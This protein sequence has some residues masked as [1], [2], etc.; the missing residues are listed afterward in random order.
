MKE[1][2]KLVEA[3]ATAGLQMAQIAEQEQ[4]AAREQE[5][6]AVPSDQNDANRI[7]AAAIVKK[8][9]DYVRGVA[10]DDPDGRYKR[11]YENVAPTYFDFLAKALQD[12]GR[13]TLDQA[14]QAQRIVEIWRQY[15]RGRAAKKMVSKVHLDEIQEACER[16]VPQ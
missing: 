5:E 4:E 6:V 11:T 16:L 7:K 1:Q 3:T 2:L 13:L 12:R 9:Q 8:A 10:N 14:A 15:Q